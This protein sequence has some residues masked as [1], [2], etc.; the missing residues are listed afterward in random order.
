MSISLSDITAFLAVYETGGVNAAARR[1]SLSR[2]AVSKRVADLESALGSALFT[3][4]TTSMTPTEVADMFYQRASVLVRELEDAVNDAR[5]D[6]VGLSGSLRIAA[7]VSVTLSFLYAPLIDFA[8]RHEALRVAVD[9]DDKFVD[10]ANGGYDVAIRI[11]RLRDSS[12]KA[13]KL[14][15]SRRIVC[16]SPAYLQAF[17]EPKIIEDLADHKTIGYANSPLSQV[18]D[19]MAPGDSAIRTVRV[20]PHFVSNNGE[21]IR[22]A[23]LAGL[24]LCVLPSFLAADALRNGD[25]LAVLEDL[26]PT[27]S[28]VFAVYPPGRERSPKVRAFID[29]IAAFFAAGPPWDLPVE[30][31][32]L[33]DNQNYIK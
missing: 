5:P 13:R 7:P 9:L 28:G 25:L 27:K 20:T 33:D 23:A 4:S 14:A 21:T 8:R 29:H 16:A 2:S 32:L 22:E 1:M 24:G 19:F 30:T 6:T 26:P 31:K 17:G 3:R 15:E 10:L 18:W 12:L 11:G